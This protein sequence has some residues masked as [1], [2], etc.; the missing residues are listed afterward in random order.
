M[1]SLS[2]KIILSL[3]VSTLV[4]LCVVTLSSYLFQRTSEL[5]DWE[6]TKQ[7]LSR[8]M[9]VIFQEPVYAYD[10]VLVQNIVD[11]YLSDKQIS[12]I[13][14]F[15]QRNQTLGEGGMVDVSDYDEDQSNIVLNWSDNK[16]IGSVKVNFSRQ[17]LISRL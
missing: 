2:Q 11:A 17:S 10:K 1:K 4:V 9:Q 15:D 14:V 16:T 7:A 6:N 8:Q 13:Q 3:V 5:N 12:R